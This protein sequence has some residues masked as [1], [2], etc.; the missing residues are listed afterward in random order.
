MQLTVL[1]RTICM[2]RPNWVI[3]PKPWLEKLVADYM[4]ENNLNNRTDAVHRLVEDLQTALDIAA[5]EC[6]RLDKELSKVN[7]HG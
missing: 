6:E 2:Q 1:R 7:K 5:A 3:R 4:T